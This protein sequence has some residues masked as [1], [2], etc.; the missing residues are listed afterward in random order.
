MIEIDL[1]KGSTSFIVAS[2]PD[3]FVSLFVS[4]ELLDPDKVTVGR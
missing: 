3:W 4:S 2:P 1:V